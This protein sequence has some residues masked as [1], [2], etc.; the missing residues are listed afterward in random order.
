MSNRKN[1]IEHVPDEA[2]CG[3]CVAC[4]HW[5]LKACNANADEWKED[6]GKCNVDYELDGGMVMGWTFADSSCDAFK[7]DADNKY[8]VAIAAA[9]YPVVFDPAKIR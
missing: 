3:R 2:K 6:Q 5:S 4:F 1:L 7:L 9:G 8:A